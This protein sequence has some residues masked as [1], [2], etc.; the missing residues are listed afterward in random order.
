MFRNTRFNIVPILDYQD[1]V[2]RE[3]SIKPIRGTEIKPLGLRK[4]KHIRITKDPDGAIVCCFYQT[5]VVTFVPDG[6]IIIQINGWHT[7]STVNALNSILGL[8][9]FG[10]L[11]TGFYVH[12]RT[13]WLRDGNGE[14]YPIT[15]SNMHFIRKRDWP[16][17]PKEKPSYEVHV[18]NRQGVTSVRT[19]Y[20]DFENYLTNMMKL[21]AD[22]RGK[23][24]F[25][26][27]ELFDMFGKTVLG[28]LGN[29]VEHYIPNTPTRLHVPQRFY[30]ANCWPHFQSLISTQDGEDKTTDYY[31]ASLWLFASTSWDGQSGK[32]IPE[33][34][35]EVFDRAI[36]YL[37]RDECFKAKQ[38]PITDKARK[39]RYGDFF[40]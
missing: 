4:N 20:K 27:Q 14:T 39:D 28:T 33:R 10:R 31:K 9:Y 1:A 30:D 13:V 25:S 36:L 26:E 6:D 29:G 8:G 12:D 40:T 15:H 2:A 37:H 38:V 22:E 11:W 34:V 24:Q 7:N 35:R 32:V 3:A 16:L 23:V 5:E 17:Y 21:R 19:R 18:L